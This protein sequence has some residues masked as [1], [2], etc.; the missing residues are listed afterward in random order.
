MTKS[1][2]PVDRNLLAGDLKTATSKIKTPDE[3]YVP[4]PIHNLIPG[5]EVTFEVLVRTSGADEAQTQ[6]ITCCQPGQNFDPAWVEKLRQA[7]LSRVYFHQR[8]RGLVLQYLN[9]RLP[10]FLNDDSLSA[11]D[12]ANRVAD[13][14]SFWVNQFFTD[15]Q[16]Q[17]IQQLRQG[18]QYVDHLLTFIRQDHTHNHWLMTMCHYDQN[19]YSHCLNTSLL[20]MAFGRFLGWEDRQVRDLG[21]GA[22]LHDI[23]MTRIPKEVV[24]KKGELSEAE[25]QLVKKHPYSGFAMLKTMTLMERESLFLIVQHH[26]NGDGSGYPEGLK[27][28]NIHPM[29]RVMR[30]IDSFEA[31]V[32]PRS[33]R[34]GYA[35]AKAL[36]IMRQDWQ[37]RGIFDSTLLVQFIKFIAGT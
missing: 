27:M 36:W 31:M 20:G 30:I 12:K 32:S 3:E 18:F 8:D 4:L 22:L 1:A 37:R 29:A 7:G 15:T 26:E 2:S 24:N 25:W 10:I 14:T 11:K 5:Q 13:L 28:A 23:G 17:V 16:A 34:E 6:F 9:Q 33:W 21:R 35:P 19:L